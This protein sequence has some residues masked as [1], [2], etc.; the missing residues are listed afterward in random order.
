[1]LIALIDDGIDK[2]LY[3]EI[4]LKHDLSVEDDDVKLRDPTDRILTGHG[5]TCARIITKYA[6][7]A[8]FC[9]LRIF[10]EEKLTSSWSKLITAL[11]WC[12]NSRIPIIHMSIG[13]S[14]MSDYKKMRSLIVKILRQNQVVVAAYSN[15]QAYSSA[16]ACIRG[17][18]GVAAD[19]N[20]KDN[21]Y[22]FSRKRSERH[23]IYA[24]SQHILTSLSGMVTITQNTNSYA[25]PTLTSHVHNLL[26]NY[27][28]MSLAVSQVYKLLLKT[29]EALHCNKS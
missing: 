27:A 24:S 19:P 23:M 10:H 2:N 14:F 25:A 16:P 4:H 15:S 20:L 22:Y 9:S 6:P 12:L 13:S 5:T 21:L 8:E 7:R 28:P 17:V 26:N 29:N 11:E 3:P 18:F 1:M